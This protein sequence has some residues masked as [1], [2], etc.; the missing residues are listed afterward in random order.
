MCPYHV[1]NPAASA[2]NKVGLHMSLAYSVK[3][4]SSTH[5]QLPIKSDQHEIHVEQMVHHHGSTCTC[6]AYVGHCREH[7]HIAKGN[8]SSACGGTVY[9]RPRCSWRGNMAHSP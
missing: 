4:S 9:N 7:G 2:K 8:L 5:G 6:I 3:C 1:P